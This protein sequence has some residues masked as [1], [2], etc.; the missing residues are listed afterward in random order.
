MEERMG[1]RSLARGSLTAW[2]D[3]GLTNIVLLLFAHLTHICL[4]MRENAHPANLCKF[5]PFPNVHLS[6][7][8]C[9]RLP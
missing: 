6:T 2:P 7:L 9:S 1:A 8:V 5:N 4:T 3:T